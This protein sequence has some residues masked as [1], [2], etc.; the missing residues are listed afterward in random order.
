M[1]ELYNVKCKQNRTTQHF[2]ATPV[3]MG[4]ERSISV[5]NVHAPSGKKKL[6]AL[7]RK[8]LIAKLLKST[9]LNDAGKTVGYDRYMIAGHLNTE[10]NLTLRRS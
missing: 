6:T 3:N 8:E 9:S 5:I 1:N 4:D 2:I 7:P 10:E